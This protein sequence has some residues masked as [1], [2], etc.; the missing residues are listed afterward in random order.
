MTARLYWEGDR[1]MLGSLEMARLK[2]SQ[3]ATSGRAYYTVTGHEPVEVGT[4]DEIAP[5][6]NVRARAECFDAVVTAL[7]AAGVEVD[8]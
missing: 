2:E 7:R 8:P 4:P 3:S 6:I 1:L 5:G